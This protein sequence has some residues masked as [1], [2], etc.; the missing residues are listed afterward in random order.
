M[1]HHLVKITDG[2][3][4]SFY[5]YGLLCADNHP[6]SILLT[7]AIQDTVKETSSSINS[8]CT[9]FAIKGASLPQ[10]NID[11]DITITAQKS[12]VPNQRYQNPICSPCAAPIALMALRTMTCPYFIN[13]ESQYKI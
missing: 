5:C 1:L 6:K 4:Y 12:E 13:V 2:K 8:K 7:L 3:K 11:H 10:N 9:P